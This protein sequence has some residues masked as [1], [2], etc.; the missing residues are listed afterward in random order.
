MLGLFIMGGFLLLLKQYHFF[1]ETKKRLLL[2]QKT[3]I[4]QG[5]F[6]SMY[7]FIITHENQ[8]FI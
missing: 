6:I 1:M 7:N 3:H 4:K 5:A 8:Q 2:F